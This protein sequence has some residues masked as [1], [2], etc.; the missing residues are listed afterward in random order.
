MVE[1]DKTWLQ[2]QP[3]RLALDS[4]KRARKLRQGLETAQT[5]R[6]ATERKLDRILDDVRRAKLVEDGLLQSN[7]ETLQ[8]VSRHSTL[9]TTDTLFPDR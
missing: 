8:Y 7:S 6:L 4:V 9:D 1:T 5:E 2:S 3:V